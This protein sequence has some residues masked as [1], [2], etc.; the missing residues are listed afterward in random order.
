[1]VRRQTDEWGWHWC[2]DHEPHPVDPY[3]HTHAWQFVQFM[4]VAGGVYAC[5]TCDCRPSHTEAKIV[6]ARVE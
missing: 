2:N 4:E 1:M 3:K 6:R 5:Y